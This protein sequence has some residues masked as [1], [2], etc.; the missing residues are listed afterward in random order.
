MRECENRVMMRKS[1]PKGEKV[2]EGCRTLRN[3]ELP[4]VMDEMGGNCSTHGQ[5]RN[6]YK[7]LV[8]KPEGMKS[9]GRS[10]CRRKHD[11]RMDRRETDREGVN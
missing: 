2:E 6:A 4:N 3:E 5:I 1:R 10:R 7:I 9:L 8:G 11:I